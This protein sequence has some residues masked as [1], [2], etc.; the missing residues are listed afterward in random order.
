MIQRAASG[1]IARATVSISRKRAVTSI[2]SRRSWCATLFR[3]LRMAFEP[4]VEFLALVTRRSEGKPL[5]DGGSPKPVVLLG[6]H[7]APEAELKRGDE[8]AM[9][10]RIAVDPAF[11]AALGLL[12]LVQASSIKNP[13]VEEPFPRRDVLNDRA[14]DRIAE[15]DLEVV[16]V[17]V[18]CATQPRVPHIELASKLV[19]AVALRQERLKPALGDP[20]RGLNLRPLHRDP[21]KEKPRAAMQSRGRHRGV[22]CNLTQGPHQARDSHRAVDGCCGQGQRTR[23]RSLGARQD[24]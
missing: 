21:S 14:I 18:A 16:D 15:Q 24:V 3:N 8:V 17:G 11:K 22:D 4:A 20:A 5:M 6:K 1:S 19:V 10:A 9:R 7:R 23:Q 13:F 2:A 12:D